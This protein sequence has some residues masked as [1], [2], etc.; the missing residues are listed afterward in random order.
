MSNQKSVLKRIRTTTVKFWPCGD[1][2]CRT[3]WCRQ[4]RVR[5]HISSQLRRLQG[6]HPCRSDRRGY[7]PLFPRSCSRA[8]WQADAQRN[9]EERVDNRRSFPIRWKLRPCLAARA[10]PSLPGQNGSPELE[11][12]GIELD[13]CLRQD[14]LIWSNNDRFRPVEGLRRP[15]RWGEVVVQIVLRER[16]R[17]R[18]CD[19]GKNFDGYNP[20][21]TGDGCASPPGTEFVRIGSGRFGHRVFEH[22]LA[23]RNPD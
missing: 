20:T 11:R 16:F 4:N 2:A 9:R 13:H 1:S 8:C 23:G 7:F 12:M 6:L 17:A 14:G 3:E 21:R 15:V 10:E 22:W 5:T 19:V 18:T